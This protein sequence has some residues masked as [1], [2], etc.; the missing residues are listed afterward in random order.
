VVIMKVSP[1]V[2]STSVPRVRTELVTHTT[3]DQMVFEL[4]PQAWWGL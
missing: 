2:V 4:P 3:H 1:A